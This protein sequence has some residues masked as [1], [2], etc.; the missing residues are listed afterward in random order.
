MVTPALERRWNPG[1]ARGWGIHPELT[2]P[3]VRLTHPTRRALASEVRPGWRGGS[4]HPRP[5]TSRHRNSLFLFQ[6]LS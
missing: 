3:C 2:A 6:V 5:P 4:V 1:G